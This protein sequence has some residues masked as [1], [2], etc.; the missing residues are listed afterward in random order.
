MPLVHDDGGAC[1]VLRRDRPV[2]RRVPL[3]RVRHCE[4]GAERDEQPDRVQG[5][6]PVRRPHQGGHPVLVLGVH[7]LTPG[8][9]IANDRCVAKLCSQVEGGASLAIAM[10]D[11]GAS[12]NQDNY[13]PNMALPGRPVQ[14]GGHEFSSNSIAISAKLEEIL[15]NFAAVVDGSPVEECYILLEKDGDVDYNIFY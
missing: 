14:R 4:G 10:I 11:V 9:Q 13:N 12:L 7:P 6:R 8:N 1:A 3:H 5:G 2:Q 15:H